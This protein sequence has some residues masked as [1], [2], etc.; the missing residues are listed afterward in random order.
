ML[1][2][3]LL[4]T[5]VRSSPIAPSSPERLASPTALS[6]AAS[7]PPA[8]EQDVHVLVRT[9]P[10]LPPVLAHVKFTDN[11]SM[12]YG[13]EASRTAAASADTDSTAAAVGAVTSDAISLTPRGGRPAAGQRP[14]NPDLGGVQ[15]SLSSGSFRQLRSASM[16]AARAGIEHSRLLLKALKPTQVGTHSQ[17]FTGIFAI[18]TIGI[19]MFMAG[20]TNGFAQA[21]RAAAIASGKAPT[22]P[23]STGP[24]AFG[25]W[26][27]FWSVSPEYSFSAEYLISWGGR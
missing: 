8:V 26:Q 11:G 4:R 9:A 12:T 23:P 21:A 3:N 5:Q 2:H 16:M 15:S 17:I 19:F 13:S 10:L 1:S 27:H 22:A 6:R 20:E 25:E 7:P 18:V 24:N 14:E